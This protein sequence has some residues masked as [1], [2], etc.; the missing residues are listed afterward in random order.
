VRGRSLYAIVAALAD[1]SW[2]IRKEA[3]AAVA[4]L[5][6]LLAADAPVAALARAHHDPDP[7]VH[8]ALAEVFAD[9]R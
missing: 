6:T 1:D 7:A 2:R 9:P 4:R 5:V 3:V 8:E